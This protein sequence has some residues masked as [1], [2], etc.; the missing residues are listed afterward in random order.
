MAG[1]LLDILYKDNFVYIS[2]PEDRSKG[3][4]STS[5]AKANLT[6]KDDI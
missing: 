2:I 5:V 6:K 1:G 3:M 4:S